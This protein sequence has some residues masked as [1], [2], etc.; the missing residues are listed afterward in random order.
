MCFGCCFIIGIGMRRELGLGVGIG[1]S[2]GWDEDGFGWVGGRRVGS[3]RFESRGFYWKDLF[4]FIFLVLSFEGRREWG[5]GRLVFW[6][7]YC[8]L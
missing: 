8:D 5:R 7:F 4:A 2:W 6:F 1:M 3:W